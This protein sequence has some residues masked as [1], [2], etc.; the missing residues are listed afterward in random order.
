MIRFRIIFTVLS[1]LIV[2]SGV[3]RAAE[4]TKSNP[5]DV[6]EVYETIRSHLNGVSE[7]EL[8]R[9]AVDALLSALGPRVVLIT[10]DQATP[11]SG[12]AL[13]TKSSLFDGN[14]GLIR[15]GSV[16]NGLAQSFRKAYEELGTTNKLRGL[17]LDLRYTGGSDYA[18]AAAVSDL[19][20]KKERSLLNWGNGLVRSTTKNEAITVPIAILVNRETAGAAEALAAVLR[21]TGTGLILGRPTAG[22]AMVAQ[23]FPLNNGDRLRVATAPVQVG[24]DGVSLTAEGLKPDITVEVAKADERA[25][26]ADAFI[27]L[28]KPS[29][30]ANANLSLT[31]SVNGTNRPPRRARFNEAE[32]VRER[33]E[34]LGTDSE[35]ASAASRE[36]DF[37]KPV[38]H[39]PVL[40]R[41][42]DLLKGLAVVRQSRS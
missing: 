6:K 4:P 37:D 29:F 23:E 34:G 7:S 5:P 11:A 30:A 25:Y 39:D 1:C 2:D 3:L 13:V 35:T 28:P 26:Y 22:Q 32:L 27:V 15:I 18:A 40:A 16:E 20:L 31:N 12:T 33:R 38:V 10:N 8:N 9:L 19:F 36:S 14:I 24:E 41:A 21:E 17:V 42:L